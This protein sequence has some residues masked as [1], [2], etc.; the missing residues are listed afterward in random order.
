M[1]TRILAVMVIILSAGLIFPRSGAAAGGQPSPLSSAGA[2]NDW[3][4]PPE[5]EEL[6]REEIHSRIYQ[7]DRTPL[8]DR[9]PL[10]LIHG[11]AGERVRLFLWGKVVERFT[12][13]ERFNRTFK[14]F[15]LR[16]DSK[17]LLETTLPD[18][19]QAILSL[20]RRLGSR[21][22]TIMALSMGGNV[23]QLAMADPQVE[24][25]VDNVITL[26]T[27]FH[28]SPLFSADWFQYSLYKSKYLPFFRTLDSIDYRVYFNWHKSYQQ[29]LKWDDADDLVPQV[30]YFHSRIPFG[31]SGYLTVNRDTTSILSRVNSKDDVNKKKIVAYAGYLV[32]SYVLN[33][34]R[35]RLRYKILAPFRF[36]ATQVRFQ[37]GREQAALLVLNRQISN[38]DAG[39]NGEVLA[40]KGEHVYAL[41]D[42]ITPVSSA[43]YLPA[44]VCQKHLLLRESD[45]QAIAPFVDVKKAR[46]FRNLD[47]LS[48][49]NE[50]APH[51][52]ARHVRD[53]LHPEEGM[54]DIFEW[55]LAELLQCNVNDLSAATVTASGAGAA[56]RD[57]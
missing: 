39:P 27:P 19:K 24:A 41:N 37:L 2:V 46:V 26:G 5:A 56:D 12:A 52:A 1:P 57:D 33:R 40:E 25:A 3:P 28:G 54:H 7:L 16:Y 50:K 42:G 34:E 6:D 32:N 9:K 4:L 14:V 10:L 22:L 13:D 15:F 23:V 18:S 49:V 43:I 53:S 48:F 29:D 51:H 30:G 20:Y 38:I 21:P 36:L 11:G 31:P 45:L 17:A 35:D 8:G 55:M 44:P 47:H